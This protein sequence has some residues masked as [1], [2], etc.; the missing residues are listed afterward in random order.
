MATTQGC[1]PG[2]HYAPSSYSA[3][4]DEVLAGDDIRSCAPTTS[5]QERSD[6]EYNRPMRAVRLG[7]LW[8][9][10]CASVGEP[11]ASDPAA[12][13]RIWELAQLELCRTEGDQACLFLA[14][15][16]PYAQGE[17]RE[18]MATALQ[19][20]C[21]RGNVD[22]CRTWAGL[23]AQ[24]RS[25]RALE[26]EERACA[27][28][29]LT[30]CSELYLR[31]GLPSRPDTYDPE[32]AMRAAEAACGHGD[33]SHCG[34]VLRLE[35][36]GRVSP[37]P[38]RRDRAVAGLVCG[39]QRIED[40][41]CRLKMAAR[42]GG[43]DG[44]YGGAIDVSR[45]RGLYTEL[46]SAGIIEACQPQAVYAWRGEGGPR[47]LEL[48]L[49]LL[50]SSCDAGVGPSCFLLG[51]IA[52]TKGPTYQPARA[53][54][55]FE[56]GC[57]AQR[58]CLHEAGLRFAYKAEWRW[59]ERLLEKTCQAGEEAACGDLGR[60]LVLSRRRG[61]EAL[62]LLDRACTQGD[63]AACR[64][65]AH[66]VRS[67]PSPNRAAAARY[68]KMA[69]GDDPA[70]EP[71]STTMKRSLRGE[72]SRG[73]DLLTTAVIVGTALLPVWPAYFAVLDAPPRGFGF[74]HHHFP[75]P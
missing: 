43:L 30:E 3:S 5:G 72:G 65:A 50:R 73:D 27:L 31:H 67:G 22:G 68:D 36:D 18:R 39:H 55:Y 12:D 62:A 20:A 21:D 64:A 44:R 34:Y 45:A 51:R 49:G 14:Q 70:Q 48:A 42:Y 29:A 11:P 15:D 33:L 53:A 16:W 17:R 41:T 63:A 69:L 47:D 23:L 59:A 54:T 4:V 60:V 25:P 28:G 9:C 37:S 61:K 24:D 2:L 52:L 56:Q 32:R 71:L 13:A 26:I 58:P 10:A 40:P 74:E 6:A 46:C 8:T 35:Q 7:L 75:D 1:D 19:V 38:E 57:G 66:L